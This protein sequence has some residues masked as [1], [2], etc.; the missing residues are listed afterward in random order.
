MVKRNERLWN[1][2]ANFVHEIR[3]DMLLS[4]V[5]VSNRVC[6]RSSRW[7][8]SLFV[9]RFFHFSSSYRFVALHLAEVFHRVMPFVMPSFLLHSFNTLMRSRRGLERGEGERD[10]W[11][12]FHFLGSIS[13]PSRSIIWTKFYVFSVNVE[14]QT[15]RELCFGFFFEYNLKF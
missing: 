15:T 6:R 7:C 3:F 14:K 5:D 11:C 10:I 1:V 12:C 13:F 8:F 9:E 4:A 2:S